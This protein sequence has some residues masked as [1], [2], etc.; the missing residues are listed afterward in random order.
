MSQ[1]TYLKCLWNAFLGRPGS[2]TSVVP[3]VPVTPAVPVPPPKEPTAFTN[4][5]ARLLALEAELR[6]R[7]DQIVAMKRE[8]AQLDTARTQAK[9]L[10]GTEELEK[11][12][13][14]ICGPLSNL[15]TLMAAVRSGKEVVPSDA[16]DLV[17]DL[18]KQ[19][20]A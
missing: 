7:D 19:L 16:A 4:M 10:G 3:A 15:A 6:Q 17:D 11:L 12:F 2:L 13:R 9:A 14:K 18:G 8:Y 20:A 1:E 5:E